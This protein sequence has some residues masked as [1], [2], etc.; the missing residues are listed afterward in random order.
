[1]IR[2]PADFPIVY[3]ADAP[4]P[5]AYAAR[6][7]SRCLNRMNGGNHPAVHAYDG[8]AIRLITGQ[9]GLEDG[10][11]RISISDDGVLIESGIPTG[12]V[13][14]AYALLEKAGCRFLAIDCEILPE[15]IIIF[16]KGTTEEHPA[17]AV[18]ELFWREAMDGA[19]A[20]KLRLNSA[21]SSIMPEQGGK[22]M[23]Y[24]FSHT[25]NTLVP[26]EKYFDSH[27][28][29]FSMINGKRLRERTQLCLTNPEVLRLCVEGVK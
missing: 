25:F 8:F 17:F 15:G 3:A 16:P 1:M 26:V 11:F 20:V 7:L 24:N 18:R 6:E 22:A 13:Y 29:Y 21:R 12:C 28:E 4:A 2:C 9:S 10:A 27:P 14:G 19:F 23:F 5:L